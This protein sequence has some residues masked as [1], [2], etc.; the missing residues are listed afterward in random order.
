M[1]HI[2]KRMC[3]GSEY[4]SDTCS[5]HCF[6][7]YELPDRCE[8]MIIWENRWP[9][10]AVALENASNVFTPRYAE[11]MWKRRFLE[12]NA[13]NV[14]RP[15]YAMRNSKTQQLPVKRPLKANTGRAW[16]AYLEPICP[17]EYCPTYPKLQQNFVVVVFVVVVSRVVTSDLRSKQAFGKVAG[18]LLCYSTW[19]LI[20][21]CVVPQEINPEA[22]G[23]PSSTP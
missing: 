13:C 23:G 12:K 17:S 16:G 10:S 2:K 5:W 6:A 19:S 11:G 7:R 18:C 1:G 21:W 3:G 20:G 9:K 22:S 14:F 4:I 15:H 8:I